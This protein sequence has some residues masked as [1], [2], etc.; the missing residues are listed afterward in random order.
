MR[1]PIRKEKGNRVR[2]R[3]RDR[4]SLRG[5]MRHS[6]HNRHIGFIELEQNK[7]IAYAEAKACVG[8]KRSTA[9]SAKHKSLNV[10][11]LWKCVVA[12]SIA[13]RCASRP[14]H[15][16]TCWINRQEKETDT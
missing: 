1:E 3:H 6:R 15:K 16:V 8:L 11:G 9:M 7:I 2:L 5:S 4:L 10:D 13:G 12:S 14:I